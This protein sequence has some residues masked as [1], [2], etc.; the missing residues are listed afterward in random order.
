MHQLRDFSLYII[1]DTAKSSGLGVAI[2]QSWSVIPLRNSFSTLCFWELRCYIQWSTSRNRL[3]LCSHNFSDRPVYISPREP[4]LST[5]TF[6]LSNITD[7]TLTY[8]SSWEFLIHKNAS[9]T[10]GLQ[11]HV[12]V[13]Y[14]KRFLG[15]VPSRIKAS[16]QP[17]NRAP[18]AG[19]NRSCDDVTELRTR[20]PA[21]DPKI[22]ICC[23]A[24]GL[25]V[26]RFSQD[27]SHWNLA[28][29]SSFEKIIIYY[30]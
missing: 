30:Q 3:S 22:F 17:E 25:N 20:G 11:S 6:P 16:A 7:Y 8:T 15:L 19:P 29:R 14:S 1:S 13:A 10:P 18:F 2:A 24:R 5:H 4:S 26:R 27:F 12:P 23:T 28:R 9:Q 21:D